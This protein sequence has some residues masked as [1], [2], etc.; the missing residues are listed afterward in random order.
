MNIKKIVALLLAIALAGGMLASC[1]RQ[2]EETETEG[3]DY[4]SGTG[5]ATEYMLVTAVQ[6]NPLRCAMGALRNIYI[7]TGLLALSFLL[8][9]R[10]AIKKHL[11]QPVRDIADAMEDSLLTFF[12][13][14]MILISNCSL[15]LS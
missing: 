5:P 7:V 10:S 11:I 6:G 8:T 4:S 14:E 1:A 3:F 13:K 15:E 12:F 2:K 9:A